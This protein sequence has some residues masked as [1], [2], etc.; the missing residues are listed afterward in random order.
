[1][2]GVV[3]RATITCAG[4]CMTMPHQSVALCALFTVTLSGC[5][6][7][8]S[9]LLQLHEVTAVGR[10]DVPLQQ[11]DDEMPPQAPAPWSYRS[12]R[13]S[14]PNG[15]PLLIVGGILTGVGVGLL[16]GATVVGLRPEP[17]CTP[18]Y[19][20]CLGNSLEVAFLGLFGSLSVIPGIV[21]LGVGGYRYNNPGP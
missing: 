19:V 7:L 6:A 20:F 14:A 10:E 4:P 1:M 9:R 5:P 15:I 11:P 3:D 12:G 17:P 21:M 2:R 8:E 16:T 18:G 13:R